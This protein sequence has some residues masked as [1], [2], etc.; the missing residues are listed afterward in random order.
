[1]MKRIIHTESAPAAIGP[2]SQA[3]EAAGTLYLSGMLPI[4]PISGAMIGDTAAAQAEQILRH[5][6]AL[7]GAEG[8]TLRSVVKATLF[9]CDLADFAAVNEVYGAAFSTEPPARSCVEVSALPK[10]ALVEMECIA[11]R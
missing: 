2:Y 10:G 11:C 6:R 9:L 5:I 4:D 1:M 3:V 8:L 7:L